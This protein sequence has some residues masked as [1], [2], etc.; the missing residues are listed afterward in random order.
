M[1]LRKLD[2]L[3][4]I[5]IDK[6]IL[7]DDGSIDQNKIDQVA[8]M[9]GNTYT[10]AN[11]GLFEVPKPLS[12]LGIGIDAIP[13][14]IRNSSVLT[15]NDL[16]MLGNIERLPSDEE[17]TEFINA[18]TSIQDLIATGN[19]EKQHQK[20]KEYLSRKKILMAWKIVLAK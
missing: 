1:N 14:E 18:D 17:I 15:G 6:S 12:S 20:A 8:R 11:Q 16:G 2:L 4:K 13:E 5:H 9:G 10:R 19:I 3:V 7:L